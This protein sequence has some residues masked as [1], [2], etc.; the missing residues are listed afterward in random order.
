MNL[1][2]RAS[3]EWAFARG[4][5]RVL[6]RTTP[7]ARHPRHTVGDL[8]DE[9]AARFGDRVA[10]ESETESVT[11][12]AWNARADRYARW[13]L[14]R[15][16]GRGDT[17]A[18]MMPNRV[19]YLSVWV[20][21]AK[22]GAATALIN[23]N[24]S[25]AALAHSLNLVGASVAIVDASLM[26][27]FETA[28]AL[29][30]HPVDVLAYGA[31]GSHPRLDL[32]LDALPDAPLLAAER[33]ALTIDDPCILVY[34]S[35]TTGLP[36]AAN[37]NHCRVQLAMQ[38]FAGVTGA[39]PGDRIYDC[40]PMYHS[41][42][43]V[44]APGLAMLAGGT[45]VIRERFSARDFWADAARSRCTMMV[46]IGELCRYLLQTPP[47][48]ADR[49]HRVRL[50]VGNG[51]RPDVWRPFRDRF[52]VPHIREFYASTEGNC[53]IFN[54]DSRP[55]AVGRVPAWIASRFPIKVLQ[56][57]LATEAPLRGP[58]GLCRECAPDEVGEVVGEILSDPKKPGN[59]FEGYT[60]RD[61]TARKVLHDVMKPGDRWFR[62][63]DLMRRDALG[64]F[65][66]VDRVG[67]T[68]RW[69]G[70]NV[71]TLE[72]A[73]ALTG[74]PGIAEANVYGVAVPGADGRAGMA[75][76]AA[77]EGAEIDLAGLKAFLARR[78]PAYA[79]PVFLRVQAGLEVTGT[80]KQRK[81]TLVAEGFDPARVAGPLF[82]SGAGEG[83]YRPLDGATAAAIASGALRL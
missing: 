37:L 67:D 59:R 46:Y 12:R 5:L 9:L 80:F 69:K 65:F 72:V 68:F 75:A 25:G 61:A 58:D 54:L 19:E 17:V 28:R 6:R 14:A 22:A 34:T 26:P 31:C 49:A 82:V 57:D 40:L 2:Q 33:P 53:S 50:C 76:L 4:L 71:S 73:E 44:L 74:Y 32:L 8:A 10:L 11:Y 83:A 21:I 60:D 24:Q 1:A 63:G 78:L 18:L 36:K 47:G 20:G 41:N 70:E 45:C 35:G 30:D 56:V 81:P 39:G 23:T 55:G 16:L 15:G 27:Q 62:T 52:G 43:G 29:L 51:L 13:A 7:V 42:G 3:S 66:F 79:V 77:E 48:P 38:A 64:Y